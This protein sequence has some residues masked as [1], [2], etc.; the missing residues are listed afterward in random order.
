MCNSF[1][2]DLHVGETADTARYGASRYFDAKCASTNVFSLVSRSR[3]SRHDN[4][5]DKD[6]S[7]LTFLIVRTGNSKIIDGNRVVRHVRSWADQI[8]T[9]SGDAALQRELHILWRCI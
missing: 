5:R 3:P 6:Q 9:S 2:T 1:Y 7:T 4:G 8:V